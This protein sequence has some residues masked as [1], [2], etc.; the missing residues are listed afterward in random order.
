MAFAGEPWVKPDENPHGAIPNN[1]IGH[2]E[3]DHSHDPPPGM[4][5]IEWIEYVAER[6]KVFLN[7]RPLSHLSTEVESVCKFL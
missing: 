2:E 3:K 6:K 4:T 1:T 7:G 5:E